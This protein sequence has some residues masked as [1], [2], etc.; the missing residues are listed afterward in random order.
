MADI[1]IEV[2]SLRD[3]VADPT[4]YSRV[5]MQT[6]PAKYTAGELSIRYQGGNTASETG[7]HYRLDREYQLVYFG[8]SERDCIIKGSA[9]ER[10]F[11]SK[12]VIQ[13]KGSERYIRVGP[14]S[15]S[16][17]FKTEGGEV[18]AIIGMLQAEVRE[19]RDF[20]VQEV[21]KMGGITIEVKPKPPGSEPEIPKVA[22]EEDRGIPGVND[23]PSEAIPDGNVYPEKEFE[24]GIGNGACI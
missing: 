15:L 14:F 3:F 1:A 5:W 24:I 21:P 17:P 18:F 20:T 6:M 22:P 23:E 12:H 13:L 7:Y 2:E 10:K 8:T 19:A 16:Q 9:L 4:L 11:N